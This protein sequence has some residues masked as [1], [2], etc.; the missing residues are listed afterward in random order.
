MLGDK[1]PGQK[2]GPPMTRRAAGSRFRVSLHQL[3]RS[4]GRAPGEPVVETEDVEAHLPRALPDSVEPR[5][6]GPLQPSRVTRP[7]GQVDS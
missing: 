6:R 3:E 1:P 4:T 2:G 5:M 7:D